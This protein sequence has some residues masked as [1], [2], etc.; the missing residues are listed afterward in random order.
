MIFHSTQLAFREVLEALS[1]PG[2]INLVDECP[3]DMSPLISQTGLVCMT[4]LDSEVTFH[5][6]DDNNEITK[7]LHA[8]TGSHTIEAS[9]ADFII[10]PLSSSMGVIL[11]KLEQANIGDLVRPHKSATIIFE[12]ESLQSGFKYDL[13]G[14]GIKGTNFLKCTVQPEILK[15]RNE[16][17]K[18]YPLGIDMIFIDLQGNVVGLPRTTQ[19][20]EVI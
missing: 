20:T 10:L 11:N 1:F 17:N 4:L 18:E 5:V 8:Y 7:T 14:P 15:K 6:S 16:I 12:V 9:K 13:K 2:K 19:L 3:Y